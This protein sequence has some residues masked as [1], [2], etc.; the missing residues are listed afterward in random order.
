M[1]GTMRTLKNAKNKVNW[2]TWQHKNKEKKIK[3]C[4]A[5]LAPPWVEE[6]RD[7][8]NEMEEYSMSEK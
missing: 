6:T 3:S 4:I 8:G 2:N 1:F 5:T 7:K